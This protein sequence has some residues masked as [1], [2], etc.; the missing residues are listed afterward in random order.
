MC[1]RDRPGVERLSQ[2]RCQRSELPDLT[3]RGIAAPASDWWPRLWIAELR[4][5]IRLLAPAS[6]YSARAS[7]RALGRPRRSRGH[8]RCGFPSVA[9]VLVQCLWDGSDRVDEL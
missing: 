3:W 6:G 8:G 1:I 7:D 4:C 2:G 5:S 9:A